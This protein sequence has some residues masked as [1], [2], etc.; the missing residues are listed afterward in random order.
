MSVLDDVDET[1]PR[2]EMTRYER[3]LIAGQL[4]ECAVQ[5]FADTLVLLLL[6]QQFVCE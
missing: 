5:L 3:D 6:G 2:D 4:G 1:P